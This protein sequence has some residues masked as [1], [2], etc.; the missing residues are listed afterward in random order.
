MTNEF[1]DQPVECDDPVGTS[2]QCRFADGNAVL[3]WF[4]MGDTR[5]WLDAVVLVINAVGF[6]IMFYLILKCK[7]RSLARDSCFRYRSTHP[8]GCWYVVD[9]HKNKK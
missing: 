3:D 8:F 6:R 1:R 4:D 9:L 7:A 5:L 2:G